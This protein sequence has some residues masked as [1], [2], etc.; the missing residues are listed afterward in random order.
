MA[1]GVVWPPSN[2]QKKNKK[3]N[4]AWV[5]GFWEW[6]DHPQGP[7]GGFWPPLPAIGH[8]QALEGGL[9]T[10]KKKKK[11]KKKERKNEFG[12]LGVAPAVEDG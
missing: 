8:P 12:L 3:K 5:L 11:K 10:P 2:G 4:Y 7:R 6:P 1:K 9:A